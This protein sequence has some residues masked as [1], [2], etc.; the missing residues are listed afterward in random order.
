MAPTLGIAYLLLYS[1]RTSPYC[2]I[3]GFGVAV[4]PMSLSFGA[5]I[6]GPQNWKYG[7]AWQLSGV[8]TQQYRQYHAA[9]VSHTHNSSH[10]VSYL[11]L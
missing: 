8:S 10:C 11:G 6:R 2:D 3:L 5:Q 4:A 1:R 9:R 7:L